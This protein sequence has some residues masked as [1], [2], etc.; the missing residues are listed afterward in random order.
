MTD[1]AAI[2]DPGAAATAGRDRLSGLPSGPRLTTSEAEAWMAMM[3]RLRVLLPVVGALLIVVFLLN[4]RNDR[5]DDVFLDD[6]AAINAGAEDV[7]MANPRFAGVDKRGDPYDITADAAVR[8]AAAETRVTLENPRA[9]TRTDDKDAVL[10]AA[11][12]EFDTESRILV[13]RDEVTLER[14]IGEDIYVLKSAAATLSVEDQTV[15]SD[16]GV[17]GVGPGGSTLSADRMEAFNR[18]GRVVFEGN[19]RMTINPAAVDGP[20][21]Q[22]EKEKTP[23]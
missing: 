8:S 16:A 4:T 6:F 18:E 10:G 12:G 7:R 5:P 15:V 1:T 9:V 19:F 23:E 20:A 13:L 11:A 17:S 21:D 2:S 22:D 3:R 14:R